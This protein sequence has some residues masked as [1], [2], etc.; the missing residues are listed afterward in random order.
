MRPLSRPSSSGFTLA[1]LLI[2]TLI[3]AIILGSLY[4]FYRSQLFALKS[5]EARIN[6]KQNADVALDFMVRELRRAGARPDALVAYPPGGCTV[7]AASTATNCAQPPAFSTQPCPSGSGFERFTTADQRTITLQ[8]DN[9]ADG[10]PDDSNELI[11]YSYDASDQEIER[12]TAGGSPMPLISLVPSDG[13]EFKYYALDGAALTS[14]PLSFCDR[15]SISRI[16]V[17]VKVST[18]DPN[19]WIAGQVTSE[20]ISSVFL[21][22][23]PC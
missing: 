9:D 11:T 5:E 7:A 1:E 10:C 19:P 12:A 23:P 4:S 13:L 15:A 22:N 18:A 2:S 8:Y 21:V 6:V 17:A 16:E 14:L 20:R 3:A